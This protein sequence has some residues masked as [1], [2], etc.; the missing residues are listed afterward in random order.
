VKGDAVMKYAAHS[1]GVKGDAVMKYPTQMLI[2]GSLV[3]GDRALE[4]KNPATG[5]SFVTVACASERQAN[6]ALQA[7]KAAQPAWEALGWSKRKAM[8]L[9]VA[10]AIEARADE[11]AKLVVQENGKPLT[12]AK[13]EVT[14]ALAWIRFN[15]NYELKPD[16]LRDTAEQKVVVSRKALGVVLA[17]TPWNF[18]ILTPCYKLGP[19]LM[20]GNT[21]VLKPAATSPLCSLFVGE[22]AASI[23]PA[24]VLNIV[25]DQN[26]LGQVMTGHDL[27]DMVSFTGST[28]TG[29]KVVQNSPRRIKRVALELGDNGAAMV[30]R[31]VDV[32]KAAQGVCYGAFHN[33]GQACLAIKRVYV[34]EAIYDNF[35]DAVAQLVQKMVVGDPMRPGTTIGPLQNEVQFSKARHYLDVARRDGKVIAG[36]AV[37]EGPG[38]FIQPTVVRD[39][40]DGSELVDQEQFSPILP[41][42]RV[43]DAEDAVKRVNNTEYGLCGSVWSSDMNRARAFAARIQAGTVWINQHQNIGPDI[44]TSG[45]KQS[46]TGVEWGVYGLEE[47]TQISVVNEKLSA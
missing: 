6:Q 9:A 35:C 31:D 12:D 4:V 19:I 17:I 2:N 46:G 11:A 5:K 7:A 29:L 21:L 25:T 16:V 14:A 8:L 28:A 18:T 39:I 34:E 45:A 38:Y 41:I 47:Y 24:G 40:Q 42:V 27:V 15:A 10:D 43:T 3:D 23:L 30:L 13:G 44:P 1:Q 36:G 20:T 33:T 22:I 32:Q 26:D 37:I